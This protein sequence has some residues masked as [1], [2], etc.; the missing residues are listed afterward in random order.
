MQFIRTK[1]G[2]HPV[3][4]ESKIRFAQVHVRISRGKAI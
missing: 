4:Y 3:K 2:I 1:T